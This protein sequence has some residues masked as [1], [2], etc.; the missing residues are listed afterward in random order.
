MLSCIS[1]DS[2]IKPQPRR[3]RS[4]VVGV[5]YLL[6]PTSNHNSST[7]EG[8]QSWLYIFW[9]LHQTTTSWASSIVLVSCISFDSYI[10]PQLQDHLRHIVPVVYLLTPT[11]NHNFFLILDTLALLYIFWLLHQ[12]TTNAPPSS[13]LLGCISFDSYIK[14]QLPTH[15]SCSRRVVYLLTPTSN[16]NCLRR[17]NF[18]K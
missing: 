4:W 5:V 17:H 2:Y 1:F 9:L 6:T 8:A 18:A 11:S 12:T 15:S 16:H 3:L 13:F 7:H 10:K 14:P